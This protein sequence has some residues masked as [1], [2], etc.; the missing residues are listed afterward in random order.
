M[1]IDEND[2]NQSNCIISSTVWEQY[3]HDMHPPCELTGDDLELLKRELEEDFM[4]DPDDPN[5]EEEVECSYDE[6]TD[7]FLKFTK[8]VG[9]LF[10]LDALHEFEKEDD[11]DDDDDQE[12]SDDDTTKMISKQPPVRPKEGR[13]DLKTRARKKE[14]KQ[15]SRKFTPLTYVLYRENDNW[16]MVSLLLSYGAN[17]N[18]PDGKGRPPLWHAIITNGID[19]RLR[20]VDILLEQHANAMALYRGKPIAHYAMMLARENSTEQIYVTIWEEIKRKFGLWDMDGGG[21]D[22]D[23]DDDSEE[24]SSDE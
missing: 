17:P 7:N 4:I 21:D 20:T 24:F 3:L 12:T 9:G 6:Q 5:S 1:D 13:I 18:L 8:K 16:R 23:D 19:P 22:D 14:Q 15:R 11:D 2:D 10:W